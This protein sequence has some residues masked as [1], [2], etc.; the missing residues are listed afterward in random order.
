MSDT[1]ENR[2]YKRYQHSASL[3]FSHFHSQSLV[4]DSTCRGEKLGH[5]AGGMQ[6]RSAYPLKPGAVLLIK[7]DRF[8]TRGLAAEAYSGMRT[9]SLGRVIWCRPREDEPGYTVGVQYFT[10]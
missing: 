4:S 5:G 3:T 7:M 8:E 1:T 9:V 2:R 10:V 6:F